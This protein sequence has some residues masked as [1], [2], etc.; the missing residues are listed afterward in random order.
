M[1]G[2]SRTSE[3]SFEERLRP[4]ASEVETGGNL[5]F[6]LTPSESAWYLAA[7]KV[8]VFAVRL[9]PDGREGP[10]THPLSV[11]AG[12]MLFGTPPPPEAAADGLA[13]LAVG[14]PGTRLLQLSVQR[15]QQLARDP[16][17]AVELAG[18]IEGWVQGLTSE[19][20]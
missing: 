14:L 7:G 19:I 4:L 9:A 13:L 6:R 11:R 1:P 2:S 18:R 3:M 10:R 12:Q 15:L 17:A 5:P 8:E 16:E 20:P